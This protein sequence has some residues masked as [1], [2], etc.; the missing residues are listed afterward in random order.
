MPRTLSDEHKAALAAGRQRRADARRAER[1]A[2]RATFKAWTERDAQR[3]LNFKN[4]FITREER[5]AAERED[6]M[7][8]LYGEAEDAA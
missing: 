6:P 3:W 8:A 2:I 7:P 4:G 1:E 5:I